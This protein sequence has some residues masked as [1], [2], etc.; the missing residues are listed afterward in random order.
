[1]KIQYRRDLCKIIDLSLPAA[2]IGVAEGYFS[3]DILS[4]G[5]AKLYMVD[6]WGTIDGV[7]GD[8]NSPQEW[9][10]SNMQKAI[11]RVERFGDKAVILQGMSVAM[12][13][14]VPD[15]SLGLLYLDAGH[16]FES[17]LSDLEA[18]FPKVKAGGLIAGHDYMMSWYGVEKAVKQFTR[19]RYEVHVIPEDKKEDAGFWFKK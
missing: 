12:A 16:S 13:D 4:W 17:V 18:W 5:V 15:D 10:E 14:L 2:E 11:A 8:G 7:T 3:N 6:N 1:M 9:H 19:G